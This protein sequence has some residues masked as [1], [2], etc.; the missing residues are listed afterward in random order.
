MNLL[1]S[2]VPLFIRKR[3]SLKLLL[4]SN[5]FPR[6]IL[7]FRNETFQRGYIIVY[8]TSSPERL[9]L[10]LLFPSS[11]SFSFYLST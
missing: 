8:N 6:S 2:R 3:N 11:L 4:R 5:V 9:F 7:L 1:N 10:F